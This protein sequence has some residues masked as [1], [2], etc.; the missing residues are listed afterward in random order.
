MSMIFQLSEE[1]R[2]DATCVWQRKYTRIAKKFR[3]QIQRPHLEARFLAR[4]F[5]VM[6]GK[7]SLTDGALGS[8]FFFFLRYIFPL[9]NARSVYKFC[10]WIVHTPEHTHTTPTPHEQHP[11]HT[12]K[13]SPFTHKPLPH[14]RP[15]HPPLHPP[16]QRTFPP[17]AAPP[18]PLWASPR[19]LG[20]Q[21][22]SAY[23]PLKDPRHFTQRCRP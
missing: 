9:P 18:H 10:H 1:V 12:R 6:T 20:P 14:L 4:F 5:V 22:A 23:R 2:R 16:A 3:S 7:F 21:L 17:A 13:H 8:R 19:G 15:T 11:L